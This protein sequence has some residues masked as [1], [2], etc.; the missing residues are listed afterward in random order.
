MPEKK[1]EDVKKD[2]NNSN[3]K[4]KKKT[5]KIKKSTIKKISAI[6]VLIA[7]LAVVLYFAFRTLKPEQ[8]IAVVNEEIITKQELEQK[9]KQLP[10]Q[11]KLFI[12][13]DAFLDQ[14]INVKLLLQEAKKQG[15]KVAETE[16]EAEINN[17]KEQAPTEEAFEQLLKQQNMNLGELKK[18]LEEQLIINKLLNETVISK[19]QITDSKISEYYKNNKDYF[20]E[21]NIPYSEAKEQIRQILLNDLFGNSIEIY[22]NQLRLESNITKEGAKITTK[23]E[24]FTKTNDTIC[25]KDGKAIIRLFSTTKNSAS[26]WISKTFDKVA[27]EYEE[28]VIAYHWQLD[29]GDNTLTGVEETGIPKEEADIF[30]KYNP[31]NTVPSYVFG[32]K[33]VRAGN[34]YETLEEEEA[35]FRRVIEKLLV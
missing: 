10:D 7:V 25:K 16:I 27:G 11:Y 1:Q 33:Y 5:R 19:I 30:Q 17:L 32:C 9:Y 18:Q 31:K 35:E 4:P 8:V 34:A 21:N 23:V 29:T 20:E 6:I 28:D 12:T 22:I 26:K 14:M 3:K 2:T 15:I 24:T 13:E